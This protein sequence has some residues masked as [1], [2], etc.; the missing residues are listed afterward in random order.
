FQLLLKWEDGKAT[1]LG[2]YVGSGTNLYG[3]AWVY[4]DALLD[5]ALLSSKNPGGYYMRP[6][7]IGQFN[8]H[9]IGGVAHEM[10]HAFSLPHDCQLNSE[11]QTLGTSLMG[12]GN[13]TYGKE[14]RN[15]GKGSFLSASSAMRLSRIRAI[16]GDLPNAGSRRGLQMQIENLAASYAN[17]EITL[18][19][20]VIANPPLAGIIAYNDNE[21]IP[22][23][24]DAKSWVSQLDGMQ[25]FRFT[26]GELEQVPYQL[27]LTGVHENGMTSVFRINYTVGPDGPDLSSIN[28][29]LPLQ[30]MKAAFLA[31]DAAKLQSILETLEKSENTN[32]DLLRKARHLVQL[33]TQPTPLTAPVD[34][35]GRPMTNFDLSNATFEE[36]TTGWGPIRR[37]FAPEDVFIEIGD[38]FFESGL[39]AHA[40]SVYRVRAGEG[41]FDLSIGY[42]LQNGHP[43]SVVFVIKGDGKELFRS[44]KITDHQVRWA[45][46]GMSK[47]DVLELIVEDAGD[48]TNSDWGMWIQPAL[49][50]YHIDR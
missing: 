33:L 30:Q 18:T 6:C 37:N 32:A 19:G 17:D 12:S 48:G 35:A 4:D 49:R 45:I 3:T 9:Y 1:E 38:E 2:P 21:N 31:N 42:G 27:R 10:G 20:Q 46:V 22:A 25:Q 14:E 23:D 15:E 11:Q 7:S 43:G 5:A 44:E 8:T 36:A 39:Y 41:W 47:V 40:P 26:I 24:Y 34:V 16:A 28:A 50:N 13:H 29:M